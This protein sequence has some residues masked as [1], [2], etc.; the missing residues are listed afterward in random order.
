MKQET[1][2][3]LDL[4]KDHFEDMQYLYE[5]RRYSMAVYC[6]HQALEMILKA[7]IVEFTSKVP[8]KIHKLDELARETSLDISNDWY[9]DLAEI[10]RHFLRVR[11][12]DFQQYTYTSKEK[13][14]PT[15]D[16]TKLIYLW[17]TSKLNRN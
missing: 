1:K 3:W 17:I 7:A 9:E 10:T 11:Y 2:T 13:I 16:K 12:P 15:I 5:G 14:Q 4:A 8:P 6:A